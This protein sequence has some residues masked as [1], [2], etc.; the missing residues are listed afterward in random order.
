MCITLK[1]CLYCKLCENFIKNKLYYFY[2]ILKKINLLLFV[3]LL[4]V[5]SPSVLSY[6]NYADIKIEV[7][8]SGTVDIYGKTNI[9]ILGENFDNFT[10]K[11]GR[12]W[13]LNYS[14]DET[15]SDYIIE[16][17]LP[18]NVEINYMKLPSVNRII[19]NDKTRIITSGSNSDFSV[20]IQYA[21]F[22]DV[23]KYSIFIMLIISLFSLFLIFGVLL[24][25]YK[26]TKKK[27]KIDMS[28][29]TDRQKDIMNIIL[30]NPNGITQGKLEQLTGLPKA[31]LS[32]NIA[33]IERLELIEKQ[34]Y[35]MSN[36]ITLKK[37]K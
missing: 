27:I 4:L 19:L 10:S 20:V 24:Y 14:I 5:F 23:Y 13:I 2:M 34:E 6:D 26:K 1:C 25:Y 22:K 18:K 33:S 28:K 16:I 21:L 32:R 31:S 8:E 11:N 7:D 29:L 3:F 37:S 35:G 30:K 15:L 17:V 9:D 12:Y 36:L